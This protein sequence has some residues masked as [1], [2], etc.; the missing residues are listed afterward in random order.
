LEAQQRAGV[1]LRYDYRVVMIRL[2]NITV[3]YPN[4]TTLCA[5]EDVSL[6]IAPHRTTV[7]LGGSG[8]GKSTILKAIV[9]LMDVDVGRI[10]IDGEDICQRDKLSLR[11]SIGTVFQG[12]ALFPHMNVRENIGLPLRAAGLEKKHIAMRVDEVMHLVGLEPAIYATRYPHMLSGGQQQRVGVARALAP[13]PSILLMDEPFGA[14]DAITR[15]KLQVELKQWRTLLDVTIIFVTH[16]IMEAVSLGDHLVVMD[17]GKIIQ[18][19]S[20][21]S[22]IETPS[23]DIVRQLVC[24]PLAELATFVEDSI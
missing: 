17:Q 4:S 13:K 19:G 9:R 10:L 20:I 6:T 14:L 8:A 12:D 21:R 18:T 11:R 7:L 22:V 1:F 5:L 23:N 2:E 24:Q 3:R 16:D 15:R